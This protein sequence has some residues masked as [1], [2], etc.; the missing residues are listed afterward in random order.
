V[1]ASSFYVDRSASRRFYLWAAEQAGVENPVRLRV[2]SETFFG[3][4]KKAVEGTPSG[5][6]RADVKEV[7]NTSE[8]G[9]AA[10]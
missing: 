3:V 10:I 1:S 2:I 8:T 6:Q 7:R 9:R 5:I 4:E